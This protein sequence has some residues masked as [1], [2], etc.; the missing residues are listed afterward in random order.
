ML[1][2][3]TRR[4]Q[5]KAVKSAAQGGNSTGLLSLLSAVQEEHSTGLLSL[6][7]A[8]QGEHSTGLLSLLPSTRPVKPT[9]Q[10]KAC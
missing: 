8:V 6:L 3:C 2:S 1:P 4:K 10:Y 9:A 5:H 7:S